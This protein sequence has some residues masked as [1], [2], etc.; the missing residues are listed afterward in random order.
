MHTI[1]W[2]FGA[3]YTPI[4]NLWRVIW[5]ISTHTLILIHYKNIQN[6]N[7]FR[8]R[9]RLITIS[10]R[11][12]LNAW[13]ILLLTNYLKMFPKW[14]LNLALFL[15]TG[16]ISKI[17]IFERA[18]SQ[19]RFMTNG[20]TDSTSKFSS[21]E[22]LISLIFENLNCSRLWFWPINSFILPI[23]LTSNR[24]FTPVPVSQ[25]AAP[26]HA[27]VHHTSSPDVAPITT[28][29]GHTTQSHPVSLTAITYTRTGSSLHCWSRFNWYKYKRNPPR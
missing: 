18:S 25:V 9:N 22:N 24:N 28:N 7:I 13:V 15:W 21:K 27:S 6:N 10:W 3:K 1:N 26:A 19:E 14:L 8:F 17:Y 29:P 11:W 12:F 16:R 23:V 4:E 2:N 20:T 5:K